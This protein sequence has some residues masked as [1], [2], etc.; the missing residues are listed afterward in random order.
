[1]TSLEVASP[2]LYQAYDAALLDLDGVVYVGREAVPGV[3]PALTDVV[4]L[5][6]MQLTYV[7]NNASRSSQ[8]VAA[9]LCELGLQVLAADVVT[10]AQAGAALLATMVPRGS[11]VFVLGSRDLMREVDAVGLVS[12]QDP[13][14]KHFGVIQGYWPDMPW[15]MLAQAAA[16]LNQGVP[17]VATNMDLTIPTEWGKAPGNGSMVNILATSVGRRPDGVAG[18]PE[19]PLMRASIERARSKRPVVVGDRL[20]TD[21]LGAAN[22]GIDSLLVL[23]GVT[24]VADLLVASPEFR[25]TYLGWDAS[26]LLEPQSGVVVDAGRVGLRE[27][28]VEKGRLMGVG[29][30]LDA[31]R[32]AAVAVWRGAL[33]FDEAVLGLRTRGVAVGLPRDP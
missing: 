3:I 31:V 21:I 7:T 10:S 8:S 23:S 32:V 29:D 17:W 9:H 25:P 4:R 14:H 30:V 26:S 5:G 33:T 20:D 24:S 13:T 12:S 18:K 19:V 6:G 16:V 22:V 1:M 2:P 15:R 27:W 11:R 28:Y